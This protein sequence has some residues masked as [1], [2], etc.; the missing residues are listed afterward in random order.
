MAKERFDERLTK[1]LKTN[2][3]FVDN[4]GELLSDKVKIC[5]WDF[6]H[7]LIN[8]LLTDEEV[9]SNSL[10]KSTDAGFSTITPSSITSTTKTSTQI[11]TPNSATRLA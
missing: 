3:N 6:D 4:T 9:E 10:R 5:A 11:P 8:L 7:A 1:L 2:P